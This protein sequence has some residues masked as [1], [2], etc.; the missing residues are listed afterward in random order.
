MVSVA[1]VRDKC[2]RGVVSVAEVLGKC[3]RVVLVVV[4]MSG[5]VV[6]ICGANA[7]KV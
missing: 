5:S 4:K 1:E 6:V 2:R 3:R 7:V